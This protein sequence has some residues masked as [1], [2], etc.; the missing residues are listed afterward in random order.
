MVQCD[1]ASSYIPKAQRHT[2]TEPTITVTEG[3]QIQ[4]GIAFSPFN[5]LQFSVK[6]LGNHICEAMTASLKHLKIHISP[7]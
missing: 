3:Q 7:T 1:C 4:H 5:Q 6:L 2:E